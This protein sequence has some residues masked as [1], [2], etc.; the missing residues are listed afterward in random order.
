MSGHPCYNCDF[1]GLQDIL[2]MT[3]DVIEIPV[4][5]RKEKKTLALCLCEDYIHTDYLAQ[6]MASMSSSGVR[7]CGDKK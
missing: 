2:S 3:G 1:F 6:A 4:C 7:F 5:S